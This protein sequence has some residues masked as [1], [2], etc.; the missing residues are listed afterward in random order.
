MC[1]NFLRKDNKS[2]Y[3][4]NETVPFRLYIVT[5]IVLE[6]HRQHMV[7]VVEARVS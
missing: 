5:R 2:W 7:T 3:Y 1:T 6:K 4:S